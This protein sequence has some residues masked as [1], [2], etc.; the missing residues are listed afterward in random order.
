MQTIID[1]EVFIQ[2]CYVNKEQIQMLFN[3]FLSHVKLYVA[4]NVENSFSF[5]ESILFGE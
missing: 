4:Y 3:F 5:S 2:K 1:E